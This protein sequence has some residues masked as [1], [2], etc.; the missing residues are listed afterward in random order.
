MEK[1]KLVFFFDEAHLLF[2][3]ASATLLEKIENNQKLKIIKK[4][5]DCFCF[6]EN[7]KELFN[8][9]LTSTKY[10][11]DSGISNVRGIIGINI[12]LMIFI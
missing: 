12:F 7:E 6:T 11:N 5:V 1:P 9:S 8:F 3:D 4:I 10:N 2:K